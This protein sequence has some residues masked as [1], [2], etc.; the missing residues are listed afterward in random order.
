MILA[1]VLASVWWGQVWPAR[2]VEPPLTIGIGFVAADPLVSGRA[3]HVH[4]DRDVSDRGASSDSSD[5]FLATPV[6]MVSEICPGA[7]SGSA[8]WWPSELSSGGQ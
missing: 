3:G 6:S 4:L 1:S 8:R 2:P 7:V 5:E